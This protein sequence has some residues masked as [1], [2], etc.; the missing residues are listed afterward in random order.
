MRKIFPIAFLIMS[1][2]ISLSITSLCAA[3]D[4]EEV[5]VKELQE[6]MK[7]LPTRLRNT[8]G[9]QQIYFGAS[10]ET[11]KSAIK[12]K[13]SDLDILDSN[14]YM[15]VKN[16]SIGDEKVEVTFFFD[17]NRKF[18]AFEIQP[19]KYSADKLETRVREDGNFLTNLFKN[20]YGR[21][22]QC[23]NPGFFSIKNGY[24]AYLC[25]WS[26]KDLN[27]YTGLGTYESEYYAEGRV[28]SKIMET[29]YEKVK[30]AQKK[31]SEIKGVKDF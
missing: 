31:T 11:V 9:F 8:Y 26:N 28:A 6:I 21:P 23:F 1:F 15:W 10:F 24:T 13:Y 22:T 30:Q 3:A 18:Y 5:Y 7:K 27:I 20:K 29:A 12:A 14:Q 2:V 25:K 4:E 19:G 16:F 17:N